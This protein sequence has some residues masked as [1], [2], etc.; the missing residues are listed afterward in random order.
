MTKAFFLRGANYARYDLDDDRVDDGYPKSI[1]VGWSGIEGTGFES[2]VDT[3]VELGDRKLYF[4]KGSSYLR[5]DEDQL[6]VDGEV[7]DI[8]GA[9]GGF[10]AAGFSDAL[11]AAVNWRNGKAYFFRGDSYIRYDIAG[12]SVDGGAASP[13]AGNW[14]GFSEAGFTDGIEGAFLSDSGKAYFFRGGSYLRYDVV[15]GH[16]DDGYPR[17]VSGNWPGMDEAGFSGAVDAAWTAAGAS[18]PVTPAGSQLTAGDHVWYFNGR[19]S[20]APDIPRTTWFPGSTGPTDYGGHGK[21][22][23]QF[24][25]HADGTIFR[26]QPHMRGM[27]GTFAWLN[28]NP[29]NITGGPGGPDYGQYQGKFNWH[30]FLIFPTRDAGYNAIAKF[31]QTASC[32]NRGPYRNLS[33]FDAFGCYAPASDGNDP[34]AYAQSVADAAG[35]PTSTLVGDL[36]ED[37]MRLM[38]DKI[39]EVE[40]T[41]P[42]DILTA[43]SAELP[44][45]IRSRL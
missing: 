34:A 28:N 23:F 19:T 36:N 40:G 25:V 6:A 8:G 45:E 2:D 43:D 3:A 30:N 10:S 11:D 39:A 21:E 22:I 18:T 26:G 5:I 33:I 1:S 12:D 24:V 13:I 14:P 32:P 42:G 4:F 27:P 37:R 7:R 31:L 9:W 20:T 41:V 29:G 35:V 38:Q 15:G 16:V 17:P 44:E